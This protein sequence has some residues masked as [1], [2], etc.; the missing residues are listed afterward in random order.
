MFIEQFLPLMGFAFVMSISPGPGNF[1]LLT[2]AANFGFVKTIPLVL[3]ISFGFLT[4]VL[5]V[6]VGLGKAFDL[7][8]ELSMLLKGLCLIYVLFLSYKISRSCALG[9]EDENVLIKPMSFI[10]AALLQWLNPKAWTVSLIVTVA[11]TLPSDYFASLIITIIVFA[12]V[13]IPSISLWAVAG[14]F[15]KRFLSI[16]NRIKYFNITM[17]VLLLSSMLPMII[18]S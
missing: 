5:L 6:G 4:M 18:N 13:N 9:S 15:L 11:Y 12:L 16:N 3:G 17:S 8:P 14:A 2:S 10:Q 7:L 1:L